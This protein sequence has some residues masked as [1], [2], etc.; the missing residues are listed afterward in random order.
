MDSLLFEKAIELLRYR[1]RSHSGRALGLR[2]EDYLRGT[3]QKGNFNLIPKDANAIKVSNLVKIGGGLWD[4]IYSAVL[5]YKI[6]ETMYSCYII[7]KTYLENIVPV[8]K[9]YVH[10]EDLRKC[11]REFEALNVLWRNGFPVPEPYIYEC[12]SRFLG[13]PFI[14]MQKMK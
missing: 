8:L 7:L 4:D 13:Y 1:E 5:T 11:V 6:E 10:N 2:L 3:S 12:D 9:T 14:I